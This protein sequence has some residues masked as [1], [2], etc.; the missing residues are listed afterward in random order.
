M[1]KIGQR[2]EGNI[3]SSSRAD[4]AVRLRRA[5]YGYQTIA[6]LLGYA[7]PESASVTVRDTIA[8]RKKQAEHRAFMRARRAMMVKIL[9]RM[10]ADGYFTPDLDEV[11]G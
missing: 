2:F 8:I 4:E 10:K 9:R 5:G 11:I 6:S 7:S 3:L 1:S